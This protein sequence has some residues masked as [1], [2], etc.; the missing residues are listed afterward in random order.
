[1]SQKYLITYD[2]NKPG[3][4]Y[5]DLYDAIK[6]QGSSWIHPLESVWFVKSEKNAA[7]I[8][9]ALKGVVDPSD[10]VFVSVVTDWGSSNMKSL[11]NWLNDVKASL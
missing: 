8:R 4:N 2:L 7:Q 5:S 6:K 3:Q 11:A 1:M 9:D 10:K